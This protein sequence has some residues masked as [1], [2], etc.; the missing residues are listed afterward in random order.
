MGKVDRGDGGDHMGEIFFSFARVMSVGFVR[1]E[2]LVCDLI[3][4]Y[5]TDFGEK[6][7]CQV[8]GNR[9]G[10]LYLLS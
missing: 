2:D 6:A 5:K 10:Y 8:G 9:R 7:S 4:C 1:D 3:N